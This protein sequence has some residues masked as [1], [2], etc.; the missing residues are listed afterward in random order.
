MK[1]SSTEDL[2][3][4]EGVKEHG[5]R[6]RTIKKSFGWT[7]SEDAIRNRY[8]RLTGTQTPKLRN[9]LRI[10]PCRQMWTKYEDIVLIQQAML[11][12]HSRIQ[13]NQIVLQHLPKRTAQGAR[14]RYNRI[15]Y[16][17]DIDDGS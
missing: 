16:G 4:I 13:W 5:Q 3:L 6:W 1:W 10:R 14:N 8:N 11:Q 2:L 15:L 17:S 12:E 7:V 9:R